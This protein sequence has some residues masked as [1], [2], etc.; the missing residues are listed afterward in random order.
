MDIPELLKKNL[1]KIEELVIDKGRLC[2]PNNI[3]LN[4]RIK[5]NWKFEDST[6]VYTLGDVYFFLKYFRT[7]DATIYYRMI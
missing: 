5:F 4:L 3:K 2:F 7:N 6:T 1:G